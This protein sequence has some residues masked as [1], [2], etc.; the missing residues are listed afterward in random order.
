MSP[1]AT[2][3]EAKA[4]GRYLRRY[5][6]DLKDAAS[7]I[8]TATCLYKPVFGVGDADAKVPR[9]GAR[10]GEI[11]V[12]ANGAT[13]PVTYP[14]E[15]QVYVILSGHGKV[16]YGEKSFPVKAIDFLYLPPGVTHGL[17]NDLNAPLRAILI[18]YRIPADRKVTPPEKLLIA[19]MEDVPK[20]VVGNH[21]PTTLYQLLI[22]DT[23]STRDKLA[24]A[25]ILTSLFVME[26][27]AEGTNKPHRHAK[28][29]EIYLVLSGHGDM[30]AGTDAE[31]KEQR[32]PAKAGDAFFYPPNTM[33]GFYAGNKE[34][35]PKGRILAARSIFPAN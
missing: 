19:N 1:V 12:G 18:G 4:G 6:P 14:A 22:G 16:L 30:V 31:G 7:D 5:V 3:Q 15:E 13:K 25:Q 33:V 8:T 24:A 28:E 9:G 10:F 11:T 32:F 29:E 2:A 34:G 20:Q 35:E 17:I 21:P 23:R 26:F 27:A